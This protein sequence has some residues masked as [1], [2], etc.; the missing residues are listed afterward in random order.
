MMKKRK[1][2]QLQSR[3]DQAD[4]STPTVPGRRISEQPTRRLERE[5]SKPRKRLPKTMLTGRLLEVQAAPSLPKEPV[6]VLFS[7]KRLSV[8][9]R[10]WL[11]MQRAG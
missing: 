5:T 2:L 7:T 10:P 8:L 1:L 3:K 6:S 11:I 4:P 9:R